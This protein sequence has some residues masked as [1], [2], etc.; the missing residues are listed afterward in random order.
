MYRNKEAL[1]YS[2]KAAGLTQRE[3]AEK[4]GLSVFTVMQL[5]QGVR[6]GADETWEKLEA[7]FE[8]GQKDEQDQTSSQ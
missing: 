8:G 1:I 4:A 5:E 7:V 6:K 2:R 3:L